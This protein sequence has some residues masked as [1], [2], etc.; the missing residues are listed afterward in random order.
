MATPQQSAMDGA[1]RHLVSNYNPKGNRVGWLMLA[2]ILVEAWDLYSIAF[3][4]VFI[5]DQ[6]H[7]DPLLLG[8]AAAGTQGGALVGA[9]IGGWLS[10]RIGRR[11]MFLTTMVLF[12][13]LALAQAFVTSVGLL[14]VVRFL[15]GVPLGSDISNGYTYIMESMPK[16]QREVMGNRWQFMFAL[17][18]IMTLAVIAVFLL[19]NLNHEMIWR[20]TLGL[21]AVPALVIL[22]MRHDLPETAVWLI[23]RGRF[24][25]AK[26]VSTQLYGDSLAM[27][28]DQDIVV[29][30]PRASAFLA[31]IRRDPIRWRATLY[32]WIACFCQGSEFST[33][34]FYLPVLFVMVGVSSILGINL[35]T[36]ALYVVAAIAGWIGPMITPRIGQ[37]GISIAGFAIVLVSLLVA[38]GA[39]Y[40]G[41]TML[42]PFAAAAMLWGHYWDASNCMT[43]PTVVARPEYRGTASGFAYMFVKLPSFLA[44][45]LFPSLFA[46]VGQAAATLMVAIFPLVGLLAAIFILPE[47]YG[48]END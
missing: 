9:L 32:G 41:N 30:R 39:L 8:L 10:D 42:L 6:Y 27:L 46:A 26:Q 43:I 48:F 20:V 31:D 18:E 34:A 45:F 29:P 21:G 19:V 12:I 5:K 36:M 33:F 22:L 47:I 14:V 28:P 13:V 44:I 35:V 23:R 7:P 38:A 4:L 2:S 17:G 25:E 1:V 40:T 15:L 37:R 24:R 3:V 16:G 11:I